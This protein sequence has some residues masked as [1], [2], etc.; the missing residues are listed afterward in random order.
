M[1]ARCRIELFGGLRVIR[2]DRVITRFRTQ[3][4]ASVL[5]YLAYHLEASHPRELLVELC[6]PSSA[7]ES[8]R[9][10]LSQ[11]LSSLRRQLEPPGVPPG[12]VLVASRWHVSLNPQAV[13]TDVAEFRQWIGTAAGPST[14]DAAA[15]ALACGVEVY[16]G[17]LL[18]GCYYDW[19]VIE[20]RRLARQYAEALR[21]LAD[22]WEHRGRPELAVDYLCRLIRSDALCVPA[23]HHLVRLLVSAGSPAEALR[24]YADLERM[25]EREFGRPV[26]EETTALVSELLDRS[27]T[28]RPVAPAPVPRDAPGRELEVPAR[29]RARPPAPLPV[30]ISRFF[31]REAE[32]AWL[33]ETL[34][35]P[36]TRLLTLVGPGGAG[37]TRLAIEAAERVSERAPLSVRFV[38]LASTA[39]PKHIPGTLA[40]ALGLPHSPDLQPPFGLPLMGCEIYCT[41]SDCRTART[42]SRWSR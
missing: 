28:A 7:P 16:R 34:C 22:Y 20:Q 24:A 29:K 12:T 8:G 35:S 9:N 40:E 39:E 32:I 1:D 5:A 13:S 3:A 11:A 27:H 2:G 4:T 33:G 36:A 15:R 6:W 31:G 14:E 18:S 38:P 21:Q 19:A 26:P 25:M 41:D 17:E 42:C 30:R 10:L 37:K 23:H